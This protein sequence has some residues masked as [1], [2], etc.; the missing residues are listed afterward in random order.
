MRDLRFP[1]CNIPV[2][3]LRVFA[4]RSAHDKGRSEDY[5]ARQFCLTLHKYYAVLGNCP[6]WRDAEMTTIIKQYQALGHQKLAKIAASTFSWEQMQ[7]TCPWKGS[8]KGK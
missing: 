6:K 8:N 7:L 5:W 1:V 3:R 4:Y 2:Q